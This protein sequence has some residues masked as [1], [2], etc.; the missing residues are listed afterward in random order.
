MIEEESLRQISKWGIQDRNPFEWLA[1]LTEETGE[2][3]WAISEKFYRDGL[4]SN[5]IKEAI[6]VATLSL[7]IAEI[8]LALDTKNSRECT[9]PEPSEGDREAPG[10]GLMEGRLGRNPSAQENEG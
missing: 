3:S 5:V 8:Y 1:Y 7:K 2:L 4:V 6:Q 9:Q 10:D